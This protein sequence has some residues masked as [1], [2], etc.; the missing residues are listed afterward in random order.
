MTKQPT[1]PP[2]RWD[3]Y[4][5]ALEQTW[6]GEVRASDERGAIEIAAEEFGAGL[7]FDDDTEMTRPEISPR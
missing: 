2:I 7:E 4:E 6:I 3:I 1:S 5:L